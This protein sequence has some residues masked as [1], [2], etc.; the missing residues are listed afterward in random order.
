MLSALA[1]LP[2]V[3]YP[4]PDWA[5]GVPE[6]HG[7]NATLLQRAANLTRDNL[8]SGCLVVAAGQPHTTPRKLKSHPQ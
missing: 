4:S 2:S 6:E 7:L 3:P 8:K 5:T 1:L